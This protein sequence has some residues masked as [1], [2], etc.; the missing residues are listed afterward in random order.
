MVE[1]IN[2]GGLIRR[3]GKLTT[4]P[5]AWKTREI[6]FGRGPV[7]A[8][9]IPWGDVSTAFHSTA[10]P[11]I[12]VYAALPAVARKMMKLSRPFG[13][14][15]AS[16]PVQSFLKKRIKAQ[17][18]GPSDAERASG[19]SIV[20]GEVKDESGRTAVSRL[21]GPEGYTLTALAALAIVEKALAGDAPAGFQTPSRAYGP[22]LILE[23]EGVTREDLS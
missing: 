18:A 14:L 6:D 9:T 15:L 5:T 22:D 3:D 1:N 7:K 8:T 16:Q 2:R 17:P 11:N 19:K 13:R 20:W 23:V 4:V 10:I 12:E 21:Q